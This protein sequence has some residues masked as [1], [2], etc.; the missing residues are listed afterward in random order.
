MFSYLRGFLAKDCVLFLEAPLDLYWLAEALDSE[1]VIS[2]ICGSS[3]RR[4]K[5][6]CLDFLDEEKLLIM[7]P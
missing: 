3:Y 5:L 7:L 4:L 6:F 1:K 2:L